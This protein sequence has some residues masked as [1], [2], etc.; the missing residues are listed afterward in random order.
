VTLQSPV[1]SPPKLSLVVPGERPETVRRMAD[2]L[3]RQT[4]RDALQVIVV[5]WPG[6]WTSA[7]DLGRDGFADV[8]FV[9]VGPETN[10]PQGRAAGAR[11]ATAPLLFFSETHAYPRPEWAEAVLAAASGGF[12]VISSSFANANPDGA[13]SWAG[14]LLDYGAY[15]LDAPAGEIE[16]APIH[17]GIFPRDAILA[18]GD[19]IV[20]ALSAGDELAVALRAQ[21]RRTY[22]EPRAAIDHYN[23]RRL[24]LWVRGRFLIGFLIGAN[25]ADRWSRPRRAL[26]AALWPAIAALL[27]WRTRPIV[28]RA[29]RTQRLP[30]LT[31]AAIWVGSAARAAGEAVGYAFG[32]VPAMQRRADA[33]ELVESVYCSPTAP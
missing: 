3:R 4:A 22:F 30:R 9:D 23:A 20:P 24:G 21:G 27:Y 7:P 13:V 2:A 1:A 19:R 5:R 28:R 14:F 12:D 11:V 15:G 33:Y 16:P 18:L 25:R 8:R 31:R 26:Y 29:E 32:S 10:L 17:K 6:Q